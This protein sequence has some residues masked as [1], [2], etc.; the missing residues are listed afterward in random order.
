MST[1]ID[2]DAQW[3]AMKKTTV[4]TEPTKEKLS[5]EELKI[6][7]EALMKKYFVPILDKKKNE[8]SKTLTYRL[9]PENNPDVNGQNPI[10]TVQH[11]VIEY[12]GKKNRFVCLKEF[13]EECPF[14]DTS[15]ALYDKGDMDAAKPWRSRPMY[16]LKGVDRAKPEDGVKF[17]RI[18]HH[19]KGQGDMDAIQAIIDVKGNISHPEKGRDLIINLK[20][21]DD[22]NM[23]STIMQDDASL[24][25]DDP[26]IMELLLSDE[27]TWKDV[28]KPKPAKYLEDIVFGRASYWDEASQKYINPTQQTKEESKESSGDENPLMKGEDNSLAVSEG[29]LE[30]DDLPF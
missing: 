24:L 11:H 20:K 15:K 3:S 28:F 7:N 30:D 17:W 5:K 26:K 12:G 9:L 8:T 22:G 2:Y 16:I 21:G 10:K 18:N 14:C 29:S 27:S 6:Q 4:V 25:S 13:G 1:K 23:I 19:Y